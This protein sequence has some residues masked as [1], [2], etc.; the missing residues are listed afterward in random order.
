MQ[1]P[2][3]P[4]RA[5]SLA[6]EMLVGI[7]LYSVVLGFFND[8]T[9]L[10]HTASY[11]VTFALAVVMQLLTWAVFAAKRAW[12]RWFGRRERRGG[13][14]GRFLGLWALMFSSKF[15]FLWVIG[16]VFSAEVEISGFVAILVLV[17]CFTVVQLVGGAVYRRLGRVGRAG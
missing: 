9:D 15:V 1:P 12:V 8:Y 5:Q 10:V 11:S 17:A 7:A 4:T 16:L 14:V 3:V 6:A 2:Q 13:P